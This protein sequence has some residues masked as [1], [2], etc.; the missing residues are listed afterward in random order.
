[1]AH[2][3]LSLGFA[4]RLLMVGRGSIVH[5]HNGLAFLPEVVLITSALRRR[6]YIAHFHGDAA[7]SGPF[8]GPLLDSYKR[9]IL[10]PY[11]RRAAAVVAL[12]DQQARFLE[13]H[14]AIHRDRI[15]VIPNGVHPA[16]YLPADGD[17]EPIAKPGVLRLLFVGRLDAQKNVPRLVDAMTHVSSEVELVIVGDGE[18]RDE[19]TR[20]IDRLGLMNIRLVGVARGTELVQ[21]YRWADAFVLSSDGEGMPL[22]VLEAMA[23]GLAI[24][25]TDVPGTRE[26]VEG[27]GL[28]TQ[29]NPE[30]LGAAIERVAANPDLLSNLS[31][32]SAA[33]ASKFHWDT[34]ITELERLYDS[35]AIK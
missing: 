34:S 30:S 12:S 31:A 9:W 27:V 1:M 32:R 16:F 10:G 11:L 3:P 7:P 19:I 5:V 35:V 13:S 24:V 18:L 20:R 25:A 6:P 33:R 26:V 8:G 4:L 23:A 22:V 2:T 14:Y 21:W 29:P 28:L 15:T 17:G